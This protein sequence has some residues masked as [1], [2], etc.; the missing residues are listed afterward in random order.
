[1]AYRN[2]LSNRARLATA[3]ALTMALAMA[4]AAHAQEGPTAEEQAAEGEIVVSG[5]RSSL[6]QA[7][8]VKRSSASLVDAIVAEDIAKFPDQNLAESLQ[9]IP[10][11]A[12]E[13]QGGE[14]RRISVRGLGA[15]FTA[16]RLNGLQ[17]IAAGAD[18]ASRSF[19]FNIFAS[20]LFNS[21]V[22]HKSYEASLDEGSLGA[23]VDL[24]TGNP[25]A[26]KHGLTVALNAQGVY[27]S[28]TEKVKPRV[29]GL[30]S[31]KAPSGVWG[32]NV[33]VAYSKTYSQET[34]HDTVRW[35]QSTF[36]SVNGTPCWTTPNRG[37]SYVPSAICN[38]AALAFHPRIPRYVD[39]RRYRE[40]LGVTGSF[41]LAP[42]ERTKLS[43]DALYSKF[44]ELQDFQTAEV[45]FRGNERAVDVV[46]FTVRDEASSLSGVP[47]RTM[48]TGTFNDAWVRTEHYQR[49]MNTEFYQL[50][51]KLDH[52]FS[53]SFRVHL[54]AGLSKSTSDVPRETAIMFDD[55]DAQGFKYDY[56]DMRR[57][58]IAFGTS[59]TDPASFQITEI[60]DSLSRVD[61]KFRTF[62]GSAEW[63]VTEDF[64]VSGGGFYR[65]YEFDRVGS[66]R[67]TVICPSV[68]TPTR[69]VVLGTVTC[70]PTSVFGPSAV[71]GYQVTSALASLYNLPASANA[72]PGT[73]TSW[74]VANLP[75]AA[76]YTNLYGITPRLNEGGT[77][78]VI[79]E[80]K[81]A[82]LQFD[83]S[84]Q[85][86]GMDY[87]VNAGI[88]Y[89]RTDQNSRG[90]NSGTVV[91]ID[92]DY[93]DWLPAFNFS[94]TPIE[95]VVIRAAASEVMTRPELGD[96]TP[97]GSVDGFNYRVSFGNPFLDPYRA[98]SYDL[99]IE[100][101]FRPQALFS[102][103]YFK[104]D[105]QSFPIA[106]STTGT[107]ASTGLPTSI[108]NPSSPAATNVEG[109]PWTIASIVNGTGAK[110]DG[111]EVA[112]Q[113]P[114]W[115]L[116][117]FL[118]N[119]GVIAN[120][121]F[122]SSSA[123]YSVQGPGTTVN[124]AGAVPLTNVAALPGQ[125][126]N[127]SKRSANGTLYYED[128][129]LSARVSGAYRS[130]FVVGPSGTGNVFEGT[131]ESLY[132]DAS[133]SYKVTDFLTLSLEGINLTNEKQDRFADV[134]SDRMLTLFGVGRTITAG[135]RVG[136]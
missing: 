87:S 41:Q 38:Q 95:N 4:N 129:K 67:N 34:G 103:A 124:A 70:T 93:E 59:V 16:V 76:A 72:A 6:N 11:V 127:L 44:D 94:L 22:V 57:P 9:R 84:G 63:Q 60:R 99:A 112:F 33:S 135:V 31:Y 131:N 40:R 69:D 105:V 101:Y 65:R 8:E 51:G 123:D 10:G 116:P 71:Y 26:G 114:L 80:T 19:D 78:G 111:F 97:G 110:I 75:A 74:L 89:A 32:A 1:M 23:V 2:L 91:T 122:V 37:G 7:L 21:L 81:G 49:D 125:L 12:I 15:Q 43:I 86:F 29:A 109:A 13:R 66:D 27:N 53:D 133:I 79:E 134:A 62:S 24:N 35:A 82:F 68:N 52:E 100:W 50:S 126:Y 55:R 42:T 56:T 64:K 107:Y 46:N 3:S 61:N 136:F 73:T 14:G 90:Y 120:A 106:R 96:L 98:S 117:G 30:I 54:L 130:P 118:K 115:F 128:S 104:K 113:T 58:V 121:T 17:T 85:M 25:L 119:F 88:R 132:F 18:N 36:D 28:N 83:A 39:D 108:I 77:R 45:L 102:V 92:R 47:N 48:V 5:F 20:E